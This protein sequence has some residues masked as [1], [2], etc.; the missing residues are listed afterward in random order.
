MFAIQQIKKCTAGICFDIYGPIEDKGYWEECITEIHT[1]PDNVR[2][3][4]MGELEPEAAKTIYKA[5]DV[6]VFP[7]LS[8][9]YG[10]VIVEAISSLCP[11]LLSKGTTPWDDIDGNGGF[12]IPLG[13]ELKW[14][15]TLEQLAKMDNTEYQELLGR[16]YDYSQNKLR[17]DHLKKEYEK[18]FQFANGEGQL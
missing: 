3:Q 17:I 6:F 7:T 13:D 1:S 5:Y 12:V 16:L 9:N 2:M 4:Y 15:S 11:V 10:H 8:E 14:T 18:L